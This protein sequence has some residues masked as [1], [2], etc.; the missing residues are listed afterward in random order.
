[1]ILIMSLPTNFLTSQF[2]HRRR[3]NAVASIA[4][5]SQAVSISLPTPFILVA[6]TAV[7]GATVTIQGMV[8]A[9]PQI[10]VLVLSGVFVK[11]STKTWSSISQVTVNGATTTVTT[12]YLDGQPAYY[13]QLIASPV[14]GRLRSY[15]LFPRWIEQ[16]QGSTLD[17]EWMGYFN[18]FTIQVGDILIDLSNN[19]RFEIQDN[20]IIS[21][22][23][24]PHHMEATMKKVTTS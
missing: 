23:A 8:G 19:D 18:D 21:D 24:A 22:G 20:P 4:N 12:T 16:A 6:R 10:E 3:S 13:E 7:P 11:R 5:G 15:R 14:R 1:M 2:E 17:S 9:T